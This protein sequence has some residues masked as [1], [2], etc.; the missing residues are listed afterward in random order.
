MWTNYNIFGGY[1]LLTPETPND[2]RLTLD[3]ITYV[4]SLKMTNMYESYGHA[5]YNIL[6]ENWPF[7]PGDPK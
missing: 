4:E 7:D 1:D 3:P 6:S 5:V 2:L